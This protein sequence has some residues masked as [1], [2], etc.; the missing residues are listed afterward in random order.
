VQQA[1]HELIPE[2]KQRE[3]HL[4]IGRLML[5][6]LTPAEKEEE[7]F[8]IVKHLCLG[9]QLLESQTDRDDLAELTLAAARKAQA[10]AAHTAMRD[11]LEAGMVLLG[12]EPWERRY[13]L[14]LQLHTQAVEACFLSTDFTWMDRY[15]DEVLARARGP[16]DRARIY[17][18][19]IQALALQNRLRDSILAALEILAQLGLEIPARPTPADLDAAIAEVRQA[20]QGRQIEALIDLPAM[21]DPQ[22][23][24]AARILAIVASTAYLAD[25]ELFPL[26]VV[27]GTLIALRYGST[28]ALA[29]IYASHGI[30]LAGLLGDIDSAYAFGKLSLRVLERHEAREYVSRTHHLWNMCIRHWTEHVRETCHGFQDVYRMGMETG[31][32]EFAGWGGLQQV[33]HGFFMGQQ[34]EEVDSSAESWLQI[35]ARLKQKNAIY[36]TRVVQQAVQNLRGSSE[37]PCRLI[38]TAFNETRMLPSSQGKEADV[39]RVIF[40]LYKLQLC[41]LF[42]QHA[43]AL[44]YS[45][46]AAPALNTQVG[47]VHIPMFHFFSALA[48]LALHGGLPPDER[49]RTLRRVDESL[50]KLRVWATRAPMNYAAKL[51]LL[52]AERHR[53]LGEPEQA[54]AH[55]YQAMAHAR[56]HEYR[57]DE[58]LA[59]ERFASF[60][61]EREEHEVSRLFMAKARHAYHLWGAEAKVRAIDR[62]APEL[63]ILAISGNGG[64]LAPLSEPTRTTSQETRS[65][66]ALDLVSVIKASQAISSEVVLAELVEKLVRLVVENA[67]APWGLLMLEGERPLIAVA[68]SSPRNEGVIVTLHESLEQLPVEFSRA[69]VRYVERTHEVVVLGDASTA[70]ILQSDAYVAAHHPKSILCMPI[71]HQK[72]RAGILYLE[73]DLLANAF[74]PE[75]CEVLKL[76]AAQAAISLENAKLYDT[77]DTRV[78]ERTR[79]LSEALQR[80]QETQKQLILQEK[81]ASLGS[82]TSGIAHEIKNPLNFV[83]NFAESA[84]EL[85]A[86]LRETLRLQQ[87]A[88]GGAGAGTLDQ[89]LQHLEVTATK[90]AEH[91]KR[92]DRI[93]RAMLEHARNSPGTTQ[94]VDINGLVQEYVNLAVVGHRTKG[95]GAQLDA[96]VDLQ[97]DGTLGSAAVTPEDLGRVVLNLVN[98]ALYALETRKRALGS[99]FAPVLEVRTRNLGDRFEILIRDNGGGIPAA[100]RSRIF[101]PFFTTKPPGEG[102]GLGLSISR[103][104]IVQGHGG[105]LEFTSEEG[106]STEFKLSLPKRG[107][108]H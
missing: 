36:T 88:P 42:G 60:L 12:E 100:Q 35:M 55:Y 81:L 94:V 93:V 21:T 43:E 37:D 4:Q 1:A 15:A 77:L 52:E 24:A 20:M 58:A 97:W 79:E 70:E 105:T 80:L 45:A 71:L 54:R 8:T 96:R 65:S 33:V 48:R 99:G 85:T 28:G 22:M 30:V 31:D 10:S 89:M 11:Y 101:S 27:R 78:K 6:G 2:D 107:S 23:L 91:G 98:N 67:G 49:E 108:D 19:K 86:E 102:T 40:F 73:N 7:L 47:S 25:M 32:L 104:I 74:T 16:L 82:L 41:V 5:T 95:T 9:A 26:L 38:G 63:R 66:Q 68:R 39:G 13:E 17:E 53:V 69:I 34:L 72:K 64:L 57:N 29:Y 18:V 76:L 90:I 44:D 59:T 61:S 14:T 92:I 51:A 87:T 75:R 3:V 106:E 46:K 83:N 56:K 62:A 84:V 103:D 50:A